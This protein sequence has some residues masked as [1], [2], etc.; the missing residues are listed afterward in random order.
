[1]ILLAGKYLHY[2]LDYN[3]NTAYIESEYI[4]NINYIVL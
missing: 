4:M 3:D 2:G 1:M